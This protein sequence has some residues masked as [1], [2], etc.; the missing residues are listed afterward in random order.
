MGAWLPGSQAPSD[1]PLV[2]S[3]L[4][5]EDRQKSLALLTP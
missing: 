2:L 1:C 5:S 4:S 3:S